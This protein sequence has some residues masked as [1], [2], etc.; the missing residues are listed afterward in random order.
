MKT[1][2]LLII[3]AV[4]S[5]LHGLAQVAD[6][7]SYQAVAL[8][9]DGNE[10]VGTDADWK[11]IEDKQFYVRFS[12]LEAEP[13]GEVVY[14]ERHTAH[15]DPFGMFSLVIGHGDDTGDGRYAVLAD[16]PWGAEKM[17]LKV[18]LDINRDGSFRVMDIQQMM[19]VPFAFRARSAG[20]LHTIEPEEGHDKDEPI[21]SVKNSDGEI[22]FAVYESGV[23]INIDDDPAKGSRAGFAVGGFSRSKDGGYMEYLRVDPGSVS[24]TI[25]DTPD[26]KGSRG[27]FAVG[28]FSSRKYGGVPDYFSLDAS[29]ALFTLDTDMAKGSRAG[30]AVGGFSSQKGDHVSDYLLVSADSVRVYIEDDPSKGTRGGFAVG[31][32]SSSK[33]GSFYEYLRIDPGYVRV[34]I[35]EEPVKGSRAGFAVGGFSTHSKSDAFDYLHITPSGTQFLLEDDET[36]GSRAGF[37]VGGFSASK[38]GHAEFL[39]ISSDSTRIYLHDTGSGRGGF[40]VVEADDSKGKNHDVLFVAPDRTSVFIREDGKS[41]AEG[42]G[43]FTTDD[44]FAPERLF[45]VSSE[46]T[47]VAT[48]FESVPVLYTVDVTNLGPASVTS[49]GIILSAG[50]TEMSDITEY[51]VVISQSPSPTLS[52]GN[53]VT[54][55]GIA[56]GVFSVNIDEL[57]AGTTYYVRAWAKNKVGTGYGQQVSFE[58]LPL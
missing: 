22:V 18:E 25:D 5:Y 16:I 57:E 4:F 41:P 50:G 48:T 54:A 49:G 8:D 34:G 7:I 55:T 11:I 39:N 26:E 45:A 14:Q 19:S 32:F 20:T 24:V 13:D 36:K 53:A 38:G 52:T 42:F 3:L 40:A 27:G 33:Q 21:F 12:I 9:A 37:A 6:G 10:I 29:S 23:V 44:G 1:F 2:T 43:V 58:T 35:N 28:G 56:N 47:F 31:G 51:G 46:G 17:F 30:F 15:T